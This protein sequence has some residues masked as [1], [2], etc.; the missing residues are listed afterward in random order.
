MATRI[1]DVTLSVT[2][3]GGRIY[4]RL[5]CD[6]RARLEG[7][8]IFDIVSPGCE[9]VRTIVSGGTIVNRSDGIT[10]VV[11]IGRELGLEATQARLRKMP[12]VTI[13]KV[14]RS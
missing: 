10:T 8:Q 4:F 7:S 5:V 2:P 14:E 11:L 3:R 12:N 13:T 6:A 9:T 1:I